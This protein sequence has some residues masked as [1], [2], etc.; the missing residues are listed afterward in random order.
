MQ[1][2]IWSPPPY[3]GERSKF[4]SAIHLFLSLQPPH[5]QK[6][7]CYRPHSVRWP[8]AYKGNPD[9]VLDKHCPGCNDHGTDK[10]KTRTC[11][12]KRFSHSIFNVYLPPFSLLFGHRYT[13]PRLAVIHDDP[14]DTHEM[15]AMA[16]HID[17]C[18][19]SKTENN[20]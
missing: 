12:S 18:T 14:Q 16:I 7:L 8:I 17:K 13:F 10:S 3:S 19:K 11:H 1:R 4:P 20:G 2:D 5:N 9:Q 15:K 6:H